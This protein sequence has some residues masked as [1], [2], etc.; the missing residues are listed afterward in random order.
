MIA[1]VYIAVAIQLYSHVPAHARA[2]EVVV[3]EEL[4]SANKQ[5]SP[6]KAVSADAGLTTRRLTVRRVSTSRLPRRH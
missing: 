1:T 3:R 5:N 2:V 6:L 4:I